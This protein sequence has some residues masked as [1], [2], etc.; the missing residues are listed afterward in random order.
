M[1][2]NK[3]QPENFKIKIKI[4][5]AR[6][7]YREGQTQNTQNVNGVNPCPEKDSKWTH[8]NYR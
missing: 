5:G 2:E 7:C 4:R 1:F 3:V 6:E 8:L